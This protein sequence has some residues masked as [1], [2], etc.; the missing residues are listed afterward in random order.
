[1]TT[2]GTMGR[3]VPIPRTMRRQWVIDSDWTEDAPEG[4]VV[5]RLAN[6]TYYRGDPSVDASGT[7]Y[8]ELTL[9]TAD[10]DC[11]HV[12]VDEAS[13]VWIDGEFAPDDVAD[14]AVAF[15]VTG[16]C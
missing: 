1:M 14:I 2:Q 5:T 8:T 10:G 11:V 7:S 4:W 3:W 15:R 12:V 6:R 9:E 16:G 13:Q